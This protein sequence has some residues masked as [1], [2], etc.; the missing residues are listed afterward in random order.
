MKQRTEALPLR[1]KIRRLGGGILRRMPVVRRL[2]FASTD[3]RILTR[4][5]AIVAQRSSGGWLRGI[6]ARRQQRAYDALLGQMR[7]GDVRVDLNVAAEAV[8]ATGVANP[9]I[10]EVGCGGG[11]YTAVFETLLQMPF[12][13]TG[14]DYSAAMVEVARNTF[15]DRR[16]ETADATALPFEDGA[17]DIGFNGVSLLHILDF[18]EAVAELRRVSRSHCIYHSVPVFA[19]RPTTYL[20]KFAY[21]SPVVEVVFN[22]AELLDLFDA[23]G[24]D[25]VQRWD[26]VPYDVHP[27]TPEHSA[28][29][30]Y[31]LRVRDT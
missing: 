12:D 9:A 2:V 6:T 1:R 5:E 21:G 25:V 29:E 11:Y 26:S 24:L 15:P 30:T 27:A 18:R 16:F 19:D 8:R 28:C 13:Y 20:G 22:R 14:I 4:E 23:N 17:F 7:A 3:Y 31:L 10:L